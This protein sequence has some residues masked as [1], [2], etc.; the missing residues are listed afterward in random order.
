MLLAA[1]MTGTLTDCAD[2]L[3]SFARGEGPCPRCAPVL[4]AS[5][6]ALD[7]PRPSSIP[8][9]RLPPGSRVGD[10]LVLEVLG[11]GA[12]GVVYRA[13]A[14]DG[15]FVALKCLH[16]NLAGDLGIRR[17]FLREARVLSSWIHPGIVRVFAIVEH[18]YL[19]AIAMELV[20]GPS[21][22]AY[23]RP[24]RGKLPYPRLRALFSPLLEAMEEGHRRGIVHRD[25]KPENILV[26]EDEGGILRPKIVDFGIA[27]ILEGTTYTMT[28]AFLGT[29]RYMSPEQIRTPQ[30]VDHRAD[31]YALGI[32]LYELVTGRVPFDAGN[33]F[34]IAMSH[35]VDAPPPPSGLRADV[36][37]AL[38]SLI[39]A[40]LAKDPAARPPSC[41]EVRRRFDEALGEVASEPSLRGS[42]IP[43]DMRLVPRGS[44]LLGP[45]RRSVFLEAFAMDRHAVTN[46]AFALFLEATGYQPEDGDAHRFLAHWRAGKPPTAL[47]DHPVVYVSWHDALAYAR[48]AGKRLPTEAEWEKA[49]RGSDGRKFPW[50][51]AEPGPS[52]ARFGGRKGTLVAG[53]LPEGASPYGILDL[54][55][56]VWEWCQDGDDPAFYRAGPERNPVR[57]ADPPAPVVM[58]GGSFLVGRTA[59]ATYARR[60]VEPSYRVAD[61][62]FRCARDV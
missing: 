2:C 13:Q 8:P 14:P 39:L 5:S 11:E 51:R 31:I 46:R 29:C 33:H 56:N 25:L 24:W 32:T 38:E 6:T 35:V 3:A 28:G 45:G 42:P 16:S 17:R 10:Y 12:M 61:S 53:S 21:L 60:G 27:R 18:D 40:M 52:R 41:A 7:K 22:L 54:A 57:V 62:G 4:V 59:L 49:A 20:P 26:V 9:M 1:P 34:A 37:A 15:A 44:F 43:A 36:P 48:W 50:G 47:L 19:L 58:R 23:V 55:G 30:T